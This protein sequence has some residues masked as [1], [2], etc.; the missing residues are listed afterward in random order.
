[1]PRST[2]NA[3][4]WTRWSFFG[5]T[6]EKL[7]QISDDFGFATTTDLDALIGD[8]SVDL[9]DICLPTRLHADVAVRALHA[10]KDVLIE[11]PLADTLD[12]AARIVAAQRPPDGRRSW[13]CSPGSAPTTSG[14]T[15]RWSTNAMGT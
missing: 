7:A 5:R 6:P 12:D 8:T 10:S 15:K 1:M 3:P 4:T 14:Y 9:V 13:T 11:L 2:H